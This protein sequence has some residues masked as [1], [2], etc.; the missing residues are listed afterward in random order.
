MTDR[1]VW[2]E[3]GSPSFGVKLMNMQGDRKGLLVPL[4]DWSIF[5][6][7]NSFDKEII[8]YIMIGMRCKGCRGF[9]CTVCTSCE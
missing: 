3:S 2:K 8:C 7:P 9:F 6:T 1:Q 5:A 4:K